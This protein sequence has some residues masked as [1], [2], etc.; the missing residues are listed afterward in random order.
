MLREQKKGAGIKVIDHFIHAMFCMSVIMCFGKKLD[1]HRI[2]E[3]AR[4]QRRLLL[5]VHSYHFNI[6]NA[7]PRLGKILFRNRWNEF[8][9]KMDDQEQVLIPL[10]ES[11]IKTAKSAAQSERIVAYDDTLVNLKLPEEDGNGGKLTLMDM[12]TMCDE[13]F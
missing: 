10:I 3:I 7:F 11:R 6:I 8:L 9:Q 12:V 1:E 2:N 5:F 13:F 4:V